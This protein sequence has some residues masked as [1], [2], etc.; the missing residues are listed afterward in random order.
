MN[1]RGPSRRRSGDAP[2]VLK[3]SIRQREETFSTVSVITGP[4]VA[5]DLGLF[6]PQRRTCG[7]CFGMSVSCQYRTKHALAPHDT[8]ASG[9]L[10][11]T[12]DAAVIHL[13][14]RPRIFTIPL[15]ACGSARLGFLSVHEFKKFRGVSPNRVFVRQRNIGNAGF[16]GSQARCRKPGYPTS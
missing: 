15:I 4:S 13:P 8:R 12:E 2:A 3:N 6:I 5:F 11:L 1:R 14:F 7:Y 9:S 16:D 10:E